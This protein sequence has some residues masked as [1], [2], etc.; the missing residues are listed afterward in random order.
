MIHIPC[1]AVLL[2]LVVSPTVYRLYVC[3]NYVLLCTFNIWIS[4]CILDSVFIVWYV[5]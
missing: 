1:S 3:N 5:L 2:A 4:I